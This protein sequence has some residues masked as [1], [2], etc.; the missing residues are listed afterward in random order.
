MSFQA[1]LDNIKARTGL[2]PADFRRL[3]EEK[4]FAHGGALKAETKAGAIVQW[5]KDDYSLGH[6]PAM[7]IYALLK[8]LKKEGTPS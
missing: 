7:A 2:G 5:L 1:Y 3:A 6:G 8:G 4:S